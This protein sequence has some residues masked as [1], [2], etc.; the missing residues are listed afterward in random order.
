LSK[1][2]NKQK[3]KMLNIAHIVPVTPYRNGMYETA[4]ELVAAEMALGVN[5]HIVDPRPAKA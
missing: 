4:R 1:K 3:K 5:A 2:R